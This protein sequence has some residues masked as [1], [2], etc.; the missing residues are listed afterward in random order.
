MFKSLKCLILTIIT[1]LLIACAPSQNRESTG[2]FIDSTA[3]TAKVKAS[4][5]D[6]LGTRGFSIVVKTFK[7]EVQL[8]G[9]VD[10]PVIRQRAASI[11]SNLEG[12]RIV[13]NNIIVK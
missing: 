7:D 10:S 11:A 3:I 8:S 1:L 13:R 2:E 9:F 12:V 5:I 4:L 6:E